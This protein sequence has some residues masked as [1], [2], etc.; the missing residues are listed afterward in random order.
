MFRPALLSRKLVAPQSWQAM[1]HSEALKAVYEQ[2]L[3][4]IMQQCFGY[5]LIKLGGLSHSLTLPGCPIKHQVCHAYQESSSGGV[6]A[7]PTDLPYREKSVDAVLMTHVLD[8]SADP[9]QVLREV[10]HCLIPNGQLIIVGFNPYSAAGIARWLPIK[11]DSALHRAR[12][13]SRSRV[14]DWLSLMGYQVTLEKRFLFS[15]MLYSKDLNKTRKWQTNAQKYLSFFASVYVIVG[16][17]REYPLSLI[18]PSWKPV[19]KFS[20]V[21]ASL[22]VKK[23]ICKNV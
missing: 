6:V 23:E 17:K 19:P 3:S 14:I 2:Q 7:L 15:E 21:G 13:F 18:K 10:D 11:K 8:Y 9:H 5:H 4:P 1:P 20:P 22:R 12:F 16:K